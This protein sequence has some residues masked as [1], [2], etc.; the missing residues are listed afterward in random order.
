MINFVCSDCGAQLQI[1]DKS[2]GLLGYCPHCGTN[3]RVP[4]HPKRTSKLL[5]TARFFFLPLLATGA[6]A[7]LLGLPV[8]I[9]GLAALSIMWA[10]CWAFT[11]IGTFLCSP[12]YYRIWK[13]G[14]G[15]PFFD[16]LPDMF[17]P[18][19]PE[20]RFAELFREKA[21][22]ECEEVDRM[23]GI[24]PKTPAPSPDSTKGINDE[25]FI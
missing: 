20:T 19:P 5:I 10:F 12:T 16:T 15:D 22:Q 4:G 2:A 11:N 9:G 17:N 1:G 8:F 14:G 21:R 6:V 23:F 7:L 25:N 3:T 24:P 18:D 13:S